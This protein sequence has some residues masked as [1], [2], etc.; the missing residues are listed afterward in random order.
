MAWIYQRPDSAKWWIGFRKN[1]RQFLQSTKTTDRKAAEAVLKR[2]D[3]LE[4]AEAQGVLNDAF[5]EALTGKKQSATSLRR[6]TTDFLNEAKGTTAGSTLGRYT[7]ILEALG[8]HLGAGDSK[9]LLRDVTP[10]DMF[11]D[12]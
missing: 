1:G 6:A 5:I 4:Q 7:S 12:T 3:L 8:A 10:D 2:Y 11:A 9:P